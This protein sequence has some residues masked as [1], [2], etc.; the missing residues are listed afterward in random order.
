M[1]PSSIDPDSCPEVLSLIGYYLFGGM[2]CL[3]PLAAYLLYLAM[4]N[5][6]PHPTMLSGPWDFVGI[7]VGTSGFWL[8]AGPAIM[9]IF[10][11]RWRPALVRDDVG[12]GD[13]SFVW[14]IPWM[15]YTLLV[16]GGSMLILWRRRHWTMVYNVE[17]RLFD[18]VLAQVFARLRVTAV[19]I[20]NDIVIES[21]PTPTTREAPAAVPAEGT[22]NPP[23]DGAITSRAPDDRAASFLPA[24][25]PLAELRLDPFPA[26]HH[27][28]MRWWTYAEG[29]RPAVEAELARD[30]QAIECNENPAAGWF[31]TVSSCLFSAI[32]LGLVAFILVGLKNY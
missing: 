10:H 2:A 25:S 27:V 29:I 20:G 11:S 15:I 26:T 23:A 12:S 19:R 16:V 13:L 6:R 3:F 31:L 18:A 22:G 21:Q 30:L 14:I 7:L 8:I 5:N 9:H 4:I 17:P 24:S 1:T 28:T 32:F